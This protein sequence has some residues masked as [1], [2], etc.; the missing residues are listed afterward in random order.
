MQQFVSPTPELEADDLFQGSGIN[1]TIIGRPYL[2]P[3]VGTEAFIED[4]VH[5]EV[6][7]W[8]SILESLNEAA[9]SSPHTAYSCSLYPWDNKLLVV[10]VLDYS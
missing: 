7:S 8:S 4:F 2:G 3:A 6:E 1:I 10:S 9:S 5:L